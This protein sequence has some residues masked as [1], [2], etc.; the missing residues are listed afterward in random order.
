MV[1]VVDATGIVAALLALGF[2]AAY[3]LLDLWDATGAPNSSTM[4]G[5]GT[6]LPAPTSNGV[7]P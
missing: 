5:P 1:V 4:P 6:V 2:G 7:S 3:V